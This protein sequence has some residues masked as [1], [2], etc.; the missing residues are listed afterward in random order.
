[1]SS[2]EVWST[3]SEVMFPR[4]RE[5]QIIKCPNLSDVSLEALPSLRVLE[6]E[7]CGESVLRSL[8]RAASSNTK[9]KIESILGVTD[10]VWRGVIEYLGAVEN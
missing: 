3:N 2:W 5:L 8:V 1:M 6:I 4:L 10:E 7:G 9:L